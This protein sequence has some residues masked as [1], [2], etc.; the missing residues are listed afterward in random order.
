MLLQ[1]LCAAHIFATFLHVFYIHAAYVLHT[2]HSFCMCAA[3]RIIE[4]APH[5]YHTQAD[6]VCTHLSKVCTMC[7]MV[8]CSMHAVAHVLEAYMLHMNNCTHSACMYS[9]YLMCLYVAY[10]WCVSIFVYAAHMKKD[11]LYVHHVCCIYA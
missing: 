11:A 10:M 3:Y 6:E 1:R 8:M 2:R 9:A 5:M 7:A 4:T